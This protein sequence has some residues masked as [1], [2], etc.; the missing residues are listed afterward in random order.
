MDQGEL[1]RKIINVVIIRVYIKE[2][3]GQ[4]LGNNSV[5]M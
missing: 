2:G 1:G 3:E 5:D 4:N